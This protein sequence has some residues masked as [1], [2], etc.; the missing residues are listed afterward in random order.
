MPD[1]VVC[2]QQ[3]ANGKTKLVLGEKSVAVEVPKSVSR[4]IGADSAK[5]TIGRT[6]LGVVALVSEVAVILLAS[7]LSGAGYHLLAYGA[8]GTLSNFIAVG[9]FAALAFTLPFLMAHDG[10][11]QDLLE[12]RRSV[13]RIFLV[14]NY[15]FLCLGAMAFLT[16]TTVEFSRGW[17]V[18]FYVTGLAGIIA[19]EAIFR[20]FLGR[21]LMAGRISARR[22]LLV[23]TSAEIN[24]YACDDEMRRVGARVVATTPLQLDGS[25]GEGEFDAALD[26]AVA[27]ARALRIDDVIILTDWSRSGLVSRVAEAFTSLPVT[28]HLGATSLIGRFTE[29]R[30]SRF[31]SLTTL[32]L[33]TPP[34]GVLQSIAKRAVDIVISS[35]AIIL[36]SPLFAI[37]AVAIKADSHGPVLFRQRRRGFNQAEFQIWKFRTMRT[38]D[39]GDHIRQATAGDNRV[40]KVG[41]MLRSLNL[42]ELPQLI[43]VLS[44]EMSLVGP[45][46]HAVAHDRHFEKEIAA[47]SRRLNV[48]PGITGWAQVNGL[49]GLTETTEAM[50]QRVEFDLYYIDNWSIAFDLYI[51]LLTVFFAEGVSKRALTGCRR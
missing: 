3:T 35:V 26:T 7:V 1:R 38:L 9:G 6:G 21:L 20:V 15:A 12:G 31:A 47:Y 51:L 33:T 27:N 32:S 34:L 37:I 48:R 22:L 18:L 17:L 11:I 45:R 36:L 8:A 39:D 13:D 19:F 16:Q 42:D 25:L 30:I 46:P 2:V 28:I 43:N 14:W 44:G 24:N 50:R 49:R 10:G 41:R 5:L 29:P 4:S 40:T 23:G